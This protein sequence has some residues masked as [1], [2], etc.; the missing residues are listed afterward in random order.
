M[1]KLKWYVSNNDEH[2]ISIPIPIKIIPPNSEAN[3]P[4]FIPNFLPIYKP[5]KQIIKV[6]TA[7]INEDVNA[8]IILY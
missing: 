5:N 2:N 6:T 7:M 8:S 1:N 4:N 3:F